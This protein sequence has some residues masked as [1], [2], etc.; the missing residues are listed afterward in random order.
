MTRKQTLILGAAI[1]VVALGGAAWWWSQRTTPE[2]GETI[3]SS[4]TKLPPETIGAGEPHV[5]GSANAKVTLIEYAAP[6]CPHCARFNMNVLPDLKKNYI[7]TGKVRY[8]FRVFPLGEDDGSAEKLANCLPKDQ[9]F[10]FMDT[11]FR[12]QPRWDDE[13]G[14]MDVKGGLAALAKEA[15]LDEAKARACMADT[16]A[17][18]AINKTAAEAEA[19]YQ[20]D[21]T[22]T[23]VVNGKVV[24]APPGEEW[25]IGSLSPI[26][27][28]AA[29]S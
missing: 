21:S 13:Y 6:R 26:L 22:P 16:S 3:A 1:V 8:V 11:L 23:V 19:R 4:V 12:N 29:K 17:D 18:A 2:Q 20:V 15:G 28:E 25:S 5:L 10:T 27:D 7:D 24:H 14:V 9:Y